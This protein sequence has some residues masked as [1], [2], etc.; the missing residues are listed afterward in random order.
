MACTCLTLEC[1]QIEIEGVIFCSCETIIP[2]IS[3]PD[4]CTTEIMDDGN[5]RCI[6]LDSV[7]PTVEGSKTPV[8]FDNDEYFEDLSW[9]IAY[10]PSEGVFCSYYTF[11]PDYTIALNNMFQVGYNF[12]QH[13]E[14]LWTHLMN[15]SSFCV[16]QGEKH[17]PQIEYPVISENVNKI[18][19]SISLNIEGIHYQNDWDWSVNKDISFKN[20]YIYNRT[21]NTGML[22]LNSQKTLSDNRN[23]PKTIGNTQEI[24]FT[25]DQ[26]KQKINTFFNRLVNQNNNIPQ[27]NIDKNNIFKTINTNAVKFS[28]KRTLER[29]KGEWFMVHL[30]GMTDSRFNLILKSST[31]EET[32]YD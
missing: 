12:G 32:I 5:V 15:R 14:T 8:F 31:N 29:M 9:T 21:N 24:L 18:L 13:K 1:D 2:D 25:S 27:F 28:G 16:F 10:K 30:E 6:C 17:V 11:T 26:G 3:C 19:N 22:G 7:T 4:D 20:M 23:Y